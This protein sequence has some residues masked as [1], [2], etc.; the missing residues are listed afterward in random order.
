V[1]IDLPLS[2]FTGLGPPDLSGL[3][4][5]MALDWRKEELEKAIKGLTP[6]INQLEKMGVKESSL[7][8]AHKQLMD[9][10]QKIENILNDIQ[11]NQNDG[12]DPDEKISDCEKKMSDL[13]QQQEFIKQQRRSEASK[14]L[15]EFRGRNSQ[16]R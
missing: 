13:S 9:Q 10:L 2:H 8:T 6:G 1:G 11:K 4:P 12:D 3:L 14:E 15:A 5:G 7:H 16:Q